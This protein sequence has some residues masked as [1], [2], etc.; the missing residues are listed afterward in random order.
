MKKAMSI[1]IKI[2]SIICILSIIYFSYKIITWKIHVDENNNI[3]EDIN[4]KIKIDSKSTQEEK[5]TID[6]N[7][8]KNENS[9]TIAYLKV[10]NTNIDYIVV[11]GEDNS[12][13]LNHNFKKSWNIAG[14]IFADFHNKFDETDKNMIIYGHD[15]KDG[16]MFGTLNK[17]LTKEWYEKEEN[18]KIVLVTENNTYYYEVFSIYTIIAEDYYIN[19][20]FSSEEEFDTFIK[21]LKSRSIVDFHKEVSGKDKILTLSSCIGNGEKRVVLHA[22]LM[23]MSTK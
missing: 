8:L 22:K 14:W 12:F 5:Y 23:E 9:D 18:Q 7:S 11:K 17:I 4:K 19:T 10:N 2:I 1:I 3:K 21:K 15:T 13:Y 16:S 6:F 20:I